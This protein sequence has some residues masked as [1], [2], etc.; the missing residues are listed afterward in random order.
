MNARPLI[1]KLVLTAFIVAA[2]FGVY[3]MISLSH[4]EH[5]SCPLLSNQ[6]SLCATPL[7]HLGHWQIVFTAVLAELAALFALGAIFGIGISL[8]PE[9]Y[10]RTAWRYRSHAPRRPTILQELFSQGILHRKEP[11]IA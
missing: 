11:L 8:S 5:G 7:E 3:G 4:A 10:R 6:H 2:L 9:A 1:A